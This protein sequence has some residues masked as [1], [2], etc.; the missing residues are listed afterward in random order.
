MGKEKRKMRRAWAVYDVR[1]RMKSRVPVLQAAAVVEKWACNT[2]GSGS[3]TVGGSV[4]LLYIVSRMRLP[5]SSF[6]WTQNAHSRRIL[7]FRLLNVRVSTY[8]EMSFIAL[9][10]TFR[11]S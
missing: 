11:S 5:R 6:F 8:I 9:Y 2:L 3:D 4:D 7:Y 10:K 1:S